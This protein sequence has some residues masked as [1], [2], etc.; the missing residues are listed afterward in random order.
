MDTL[1][2]SIFLTYEKFLKRIVAKSLPEKRPM[3]NLEMGTDLPYEEEYAIA[4]LSPHSFYHAW[5]FPK[6]IDHYF[7]RYVLYEDVNNDI[8]DNWKQV[9]LSFLKKISYKHKGK[10]LIIKSLVDT[11]KIRLLLE[12]FPDAKF[13]Y[14]YRNPYE[15]YMSTWKLYESILPLFSF[16]HIDK[17]KF[18]NSILY[19][20][21][22]LYEKYLQEKKLI[23]QENLIELRYK[24][25]V[26]EPLQSLEMIYTQFG[27]PGFKQAKPVFENYLKKHSVYE[28]NHFI[29]DEQTKKKVYTEWKVIFKKFGYNQ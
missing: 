22:R 20:Y 26:K 7:N 6:A 10:Q 2:P 25:F 29:I 8:I 18:D 12:L 17:E 14:L 28:R 15:V 4:N 5:Y 13:I 27:M 1:D 3:D 9:Y 16:Q 21:K 19:I 23:P 24:E 11:A